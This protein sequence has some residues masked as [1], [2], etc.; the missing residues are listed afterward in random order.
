MLV[1]V[2]RRQAVEVGQ[3]SYSV[4]SISR[5][6]DAEGRASQA[7]ALLQQDLPEAMARLT[8]H[9]LPGACAARESDLIVYRTFFESCDALDRAGVPQAIRRTNEMLRR[10]TVAQRSARAFCRRGANT[11]VVVATHL[12]DQET[13]DAAALFLANSAGLCDLPLLVL[14]SPLYPVCSEALWERTS[15]V[16]FSQGGELGLALLG[17]SQLHFMGGWFD[18]CLAYSVNCALGQVLA[19][20]GRDNIQFSIHAKHC[21]AADPAIDMEKLLEDVCRGEQGTPRNVLPSWPGVFASAFV[22]F[23]RNHNLC[24][25]DEYGARVESGRLKARYEHLDSGKKLEIV[26]C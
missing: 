18:H 6:S 7:A 17:A 12:P 21:Q 8:V 3:E 26:V 11:A 1:E 16:Q 19:R 9:T 23:I 24:L 25:L 15:L 2:Q 4:A 13:Q 5:S 14:A 22:N 20:R 10:M